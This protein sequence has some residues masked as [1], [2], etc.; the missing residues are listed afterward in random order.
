PFRF[1]DLP[2]PLLQQPLAARF[3]RSRAS[4]SPRRSPGHISPPP[5]PPS[6]RLSPRFRFV[7]SP[8][9][10]CL[11]RLTARRCR[12]RLRLSP[13]L[14]PPPSVF[15]PPPTAQSPEQTAACPPPQPNAAG[16]ASPSRAL[17]RNAPSRLRCPRR[18][19]RRCKRSRHHPAP[20]ARR[21]DCR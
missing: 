8:V 11:Q 18:S 21:A 12:R 6:R 16:A 19:P 20:T 14:P 13:A 1:V 10:P 15:P 4:H 7:H 9:L 2:V 17:P 5:L 3:R